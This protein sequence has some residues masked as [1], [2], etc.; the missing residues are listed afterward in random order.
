M[1]FGL[2]LAGIVIGISMAALFGLL[3][4]PVALIL[5]AIILTPYLFF[6]FILSINVVDDHLVLHTMQLFRKKKTLIHI[7]EIELQLFYV[8]PKP[9]RKGFYSMYVIRNNKVIH[10]VESDMDRLRAFILDFNQKKAGI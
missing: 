5:S 2:M 7:K 8:P 6:N 3:I 4:W 9:R 10:A 1:T